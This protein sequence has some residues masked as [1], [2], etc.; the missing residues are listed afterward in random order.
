MFWNGNERLHYVI[1]LIIHLSLLLLLLIYLFS[2]MIC[3]KKTCIDFNDCRNWELPANFESCS[4]HL[5]FACSV[6][7][8]IF[9]LALWF[10]SLINEFF[11]LIICYCNYIGHCNKW[12]RTQL[13]NLRL[14][15]FCFMICEFIGICNFPDINLRFYFGLIM[16]RSYLASHLVE[17]TR[18]CLAWFVD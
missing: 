13:G 14:E 9:S 17:R 5:I 10:L 15:E 8:G 1:R 11:L 3:C 12:A 2:Q 7:R 16:L 6:R 4:L 18:Y